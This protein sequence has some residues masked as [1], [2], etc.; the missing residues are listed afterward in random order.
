M[1]TI[2]KAIPSDAKELMKLNTIFN[3]ENSTTLEKM[4]NMLHTNKDEIVYVASYNEILVGFSCAYIMRSACYSYNYGEVT[5]L[6][7][8]K[9][10]RKKGIG[11]KLLQHTENELSEHGVTHIHMLTHSSNIVAQSLYH[12]CGYTDTSEILLDKNI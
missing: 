8:L 5:E 2:R 12:S 4:E 11:R 9:E 10:Y 3:G 6:F 1:I 7:V